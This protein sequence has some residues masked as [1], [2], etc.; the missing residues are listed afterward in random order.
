MEFIPNTVLADFSLE[1]HL[2]VFELCCIFL[3]VD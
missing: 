1:V 2:T 3:L